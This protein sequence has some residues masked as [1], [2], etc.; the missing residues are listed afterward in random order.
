MES[1]YTHCVP[2]QNKGPYFKPQPQKEG[3][4]EDPNK[5]PILRT[6]DASRLQDGFPAFTSGFCEVIYGRVIPGMCVTMIF[7]NFY[8]AW[9]AVRLMRKEKTTAVCLGILRITA[10]LLRRCCALWLL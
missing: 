3:T 8:Y 10:D 4:R 1:V 9:M 2:S 5:R 7:G 6:Y